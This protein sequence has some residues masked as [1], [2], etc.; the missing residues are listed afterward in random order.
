MTRNYLVIII[1]TLEIVV[2]N[3]LVTLHKGSAQESV[4]SCYRKQTDQF[5]VA[6]IYDRSASYAQFGKQFVKEILPQFARKLSYNFPGT[7]YAITAFADYTAEQHPKLVP[8]RTRR[9]TFPIK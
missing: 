6:F 2:L 5:Q 8:R 4:N 3:I 9:Q 7:E 1:F